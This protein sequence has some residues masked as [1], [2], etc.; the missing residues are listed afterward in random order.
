MFSTTFGALQRWQ[1]DAFGQL[2]AGGD[3]S[4]TTRGRVV[5]AGA[6]H[7]LLCF[8]EG[9]ATPLG[10]DGMLTEYPR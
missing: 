7:G 1:E 5:L 10:L 9:G 8:P 3:E 6:V 4:F 2:Q